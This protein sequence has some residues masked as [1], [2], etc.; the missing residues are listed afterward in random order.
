[1]G[2]IGSG[3]FVGS[4]EAS[5]VLTACNYFNGNWSHKLTELA[6]HEKTHVVLITPSYL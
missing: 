3:L 4:P 6:W 2:I 1:M 5:I